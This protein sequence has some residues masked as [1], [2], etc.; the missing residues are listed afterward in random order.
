[1]LEKE[2]N[3]ARLS[4]VRALESSSILSGMGHDI[5]TP[6]NSIIGMTSILLQDESL[7]PDQK[8]SVETIKVCSDALMKVLNDILDFSRLESRRL[9]LNLQP[10][11]LQ[12]L[13][14]ETLN[15]IATDA[16]GKGLVLSYRFNEAVPTCIIQDSMRLRQIILNLLDN[17]VKNTDWGEIRINISCRR[18]QRTQGAQEVHF[19][20]QDTGKGIPSY[21]IDELFLPFGK[22]EIL[23]SR[24]YSDSG[25]GLAISK[26]L[27]ELMGGEIWVESAENIG[28]TFHFTIK[29]D[30]EQENQ[31]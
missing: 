31:K 19:A 27:V 8:E 9:T 13:V 21:L 22:K 16:T 29:A 6:M 11:N 5:R 17:A 7:T 23:R 15:L 30:P 20:I 14:E 12:S 1:M 2:L 26:G 3:E 24:E 10:F 28:S 18:K 4:D 25:L